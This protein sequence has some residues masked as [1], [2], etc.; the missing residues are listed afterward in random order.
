MMIISIK[1]TMCDRNE[2]RYAI[3]CA[4]EISADDYVEQSDKLIWVL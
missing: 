2:T 1:Y 4:T 3:V